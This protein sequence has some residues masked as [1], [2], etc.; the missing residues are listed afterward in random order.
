M[1]S[2]CTLTSVTSSQ[3]QYISS[4]FSRPDIK[5]SCELTCSGSVEGACVY[6]NYFPL[7]SKQMT[8]MTQKPDSLR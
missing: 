8:Q 7:T 5:L 4:P 2:N 6:T 1:R 3:W